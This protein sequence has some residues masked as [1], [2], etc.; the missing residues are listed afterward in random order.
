MLTMKDITREGNPVL[1]EVCKEVTFPLSLETKKTLIDMIGYLFNS[2]DEEKAKQYGLRPG[3]GIAAPQVGSTDKMFVVLATDENG[4]QFFMPVI[5]PEIIKTSKA[6]CYLN[7]GE[8]C[9]SVD[10][11]T[12]G[13]TPRYRK[14]TVKFTLFNIQ[15]GK[16]E[17]KKMELS[18]Y[19]AIVFQHEYDH[20][21]GKLYVDTMITEKEAKEQG[22]E[23]L[24]EETEEE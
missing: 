7:G 17:T 8:G 1:R 3:V 22:I 23:P 13:L 2:Q 9:L 14:I 4:K 11:T 21:F 12:T 10:R 5:N 16:L 19:I 24:W 15:T 18:N 6:M 20:L